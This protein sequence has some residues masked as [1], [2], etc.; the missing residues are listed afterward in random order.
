[1]VF[2]GELTV[3]QQNHAD[4]ID[5]VEGLTRALKSGQKTIAAPDVKVTVEAPSVT[6][7]SAT[8]NVQVTTPKHT[9]A[10]YEF[11]IERDEDSRI[12]RVIARPID[13]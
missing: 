5:A 8:P 7:Q 3:E 10:T 1:M 11:I 4:M 2:T 6:V 12:A 9:P 13:G